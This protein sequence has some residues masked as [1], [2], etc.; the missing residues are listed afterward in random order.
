[1]KVVIKLGGYVGVAYFV[2]NAV[3]IGNSF[4]RSNIDSSVFDKPLDPSKI[5]PD[6]ENVLEAYR[7]NKPS[8][9]LR[10]RTHQNIHFRDPVVISIGQDEMVEAVRAISRIE[11]N[12]LKYTVDGSSVVIHSRYSALGIKFEL[13]SRLYIDYDADGAITGITEHWNGMPFFK[14]PLSTLIRRANG[15]L[16][17][18]IITTILK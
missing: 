7:G 6:I 5:T 13:T 12:L 2:A 8:K 15:L 3:Q 16:A 11:P 1:M 14:N 4:F 17:Y 10:E 9:F 18:L